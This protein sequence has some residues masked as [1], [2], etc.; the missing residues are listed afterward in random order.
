M[1]TPVSPQ[2]TMPV[3]T[4][5]PE[6]K[7][8][9]QTYV[10]TDPPYI[11]G[12][13]TLVGPKEGAGPLGA[14]FHQ[15]LSEP[16]WQEPSWERAE[17]KM[18]TTAV[19]A[20]I[21][22][23]GWGIPDVD[24]F[25]A[26][27]LLNQ[28]MAANISA[29]SI[30]IPFFGI[31][32]A[33]STMAQGLALGAMLLDGGFAHRVVTAAS[34]HHHTAERQYR[35]PNEL[36]TQ[37]PMTAQWTV[38]GSGAAALAAGQVPGPPAGTG[39]AETQAYVEGAGGQ[40]TANIRVTHV[41]VGKIMDLG[42]KDAANLGPA[43]APA[44]AHT[45]LTH[46]QDTGRQVSDYD[47]IVTGDLGQ[48]GLEMAF[49]L[50]RSEGTD[51]GKRLTDCGVL[52]YNHERQDTHAG[53]SGCGCSAVVLLGYLLRLLNEGAYHRI[54]FVGTG[55]LFSPT[56]FQQGESIPGVAHGI[57]LESQTTMWQH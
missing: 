20:A 31:F 11:A 5:K 36:G 30:G 2:E 50:L 29:R 7:V 57:V 41:T 23:A 4:P 55:A 44:A 27:D 35:V 47:L 32:G 54:L 18:M 26:G 52:I 15:V 28:I 49:Q 8:G 48:V 12:A 6:K 19:E 45:I 56:S 46:L 33:C 21:A 51:P 34:S 10:M 14:A 39:T 43:M 25:L 24:L 22:A 38:T 9:A 37:R 17:A 42:Q 3:V 16:Q 1:I 13:Y 40:S 53:G